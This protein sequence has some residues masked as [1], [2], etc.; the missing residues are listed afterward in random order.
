MKIS[1]LTVCRNA[2]GTIERTIASFL[3]QDY[4]QKEMIVI[5]GASNDRTVAIAEGLQSPH[6]RILSEPDRGMYDALNKGL[7]IYAGDVVGVLNADDR[8]HD[9]HV[10]SRAAEALEDH[11]AIHGDL[12][13]HDHQG[14]VVRRWRGTPPPPSGFASGWMPAHPTF[15]VRRHVVDAVGSFDL[16]LPTAADY[17]WM[18]RAI[19]IH[20]ARI[21]H[22]PHV[23]IDMAL[24]GR[25]TSS[26]SAHLRH[27]LEALAARR[28]WLN[29]GLVD[30]ALFAKPASKLTQF[31]RFSRGAR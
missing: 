6:V 1:V 18:L 17:D 23:M 22:V 20:G 31:A 15:Y 5:D 9:D 10:L 30:W 12:D 8:Y 14:R 26:L 13:F 25:S 29:S 24:G 7:A 2:E 28:R 3:S 21:R 11:D 16:A 4:A 27:N 19:D